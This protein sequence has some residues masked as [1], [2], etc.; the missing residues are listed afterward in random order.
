MPIKKQEFYEGAALHLL[1]R[2][3][4]VKSIRYD[5]PFFFLNDRMTVLLKYSTKIRSPWGFSFT[6]EE[7]RQISF[8][9]TRQPTVIGLV[10][11]S[12][13]IAA[14]GY[15]SYLTIASLRD[16]SVYVSCY[17]DHGEHYEIGGP[18]GQLK[19]KV[20]PSSWQRILEDGAEHEAQ[21]PGIE[22]IAQADP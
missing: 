22:T 6:E 4:R 7:Q 2:S 17:R 11:G 16:A 19:R 15:E 18:D 1:V 14:L 9:A 10:C 21:R 5:P 13:G 8:R 3:G 20:A 12:D